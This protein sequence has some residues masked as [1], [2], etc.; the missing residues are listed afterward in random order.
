MDTF[1]SRKRRKISSTTQQETTQQTNTPSVS[2]DE[3]TDFKLA[4]LSSLHPNVDQN[5][6]L[7]ILLAHE[8]SVESSSNSLKA[9][10]SPPRK[11]SAATGYQSSLLSNF[12]PSRKN[13]G[14]DTSPRKLLSKR[15]K[16]LH[17]FSPEDVA[18]YT[19]CSIIH[20]FLPAEEANDLLKELL[21]EANTFE[22][23]TFKLF[24]NVVQ[25]P[26]TTSFYVEG[27]EEMRKQQTEYIYNGGL[28][29]VGLG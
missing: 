21:E 9:G 19:P 25:S 14:L 22:R 24:D 18:T 6:L 27:L 1:V 8:G 28:L 10:Y 17:L 23:M 13:K 16:T 29:T 7:D 11:A 2:E 15:G 26:H 5:V 12:T 20:N 4:L 3:S